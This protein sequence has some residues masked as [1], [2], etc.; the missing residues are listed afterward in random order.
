MIKSAFW[1]V[2]KRTVGGLEG[3]RNLSTK[4]KEDKIRTNRNF[5]AVVVKG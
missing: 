5:V 3:E 4:G 1:S 2:E